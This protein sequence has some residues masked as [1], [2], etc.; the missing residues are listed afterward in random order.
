MI[1]LGLIFLPRW[2]PGFPDVIDIFVLTP[3]N[4]LLS[5]LLSM[6]G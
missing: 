4:L 6:V 3:A 5:A 1:L 2:L